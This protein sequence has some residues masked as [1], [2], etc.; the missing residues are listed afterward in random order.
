MHVENLSTKLKK[1]SICFGV[2]S[3][4]FCSYSIYTYVSQEKAMGPN[5]HRLGAT[6]SGETYDLSSVSSQFSIFI[7]GML[8]AQ[9]K[10]G[11]NAATTS[12][13]STV[14]GTFKKLLSFVCLA[15][16]AHFAKINA[17]NNYL[18]NFFSV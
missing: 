11:Y 7:W 4:A 12:E 9:A 17:E 1:M 15:T 18:E 14:Q 3:A 2:T 8:M 6:S 13:K 10:T 16:V 5:S